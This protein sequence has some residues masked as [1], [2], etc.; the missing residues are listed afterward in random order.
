M[1]V[2]G[3]RRWEPLFFCNSGIKR[4]CHVDDLAQG[5][6]PFPVRLYRAC[7]DLND[8]LFGFWNPIITLLGHLPSLPLEND[9]TKFSCTADRNLDWVSKEQ[10]SNLIVPPVLILLLRLISCI[11]LLYGWKFPPFH[12]IGDT[13]VNHFACQFN[14][15]PDVISRKAWSWAAV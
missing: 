2:G 8:G 4:T 3:N 14:H 7:Y 10:F 6:S 9:G 15:V 11:L 1:Y 12:H 5:C 13:S